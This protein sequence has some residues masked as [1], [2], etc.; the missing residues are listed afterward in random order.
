MSW[1][2]ENQFD[3]LICSWPDWESN[4]KYAFWPNM[5]TAQKKNKPLKE[6][7]SKPNCDYPIDLT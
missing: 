7:P 2:P 1:L 4:K 3:D 5:Q 6:L